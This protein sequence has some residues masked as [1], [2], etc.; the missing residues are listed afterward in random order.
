[1]VLR[2]EIVVSKT[3][4]FKTVQAI[5]T[6]ELVKHLQG[7]QERT[8]TFCRKFLNALGLRVVRFNA[9][10]VDKELSLRIC[11][12][13]DLPWLKRRFDAELFLVAAG[14]EVMPFRSM[15]SFRNW[16]NST[17]NLLYLIKI[18][19]HGKQRILGFIGF[20]GFRAE[21]CLWMSLAIF[22]ANDRRRGY[23][24]RAVQLVTDFL[25]HK[26]GI[27]RVFA[28]IVE[29]NRASLSFFQACS[30]RLKGES[31]AHQPRTLHENC[32][33]FQSR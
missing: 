16:L 17:F 29:R 26:T 22:D 1:M 15:V 14:R 25:Q 12:F 5:Q 23:G 21:D 2:T 31:A 13:W 6:V 24:A 3:H 30:F 18:Q 33:G 10:L 28:E 19:E 32:P 4:I 27:K 20:Y 8:A 11:R 9:I 7:S